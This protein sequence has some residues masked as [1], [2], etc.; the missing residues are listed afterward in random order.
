MTLSPYLVGL[1]TGLSLIIA[2]GA[3]NAFVLRH[4]LRGEHVLAVCLT[5]ALSDAIL[6][7]L[8]VTGFGRITALLPWL[9]EVM[10]YAGAA[11]LIWYGAR[12]LR[13]ALSS[14]AALVVEARRSS[15]GPGRTILA[16][17]AITWLNPHVWLDTVVL[18]GAI[19]TRF[20]DARFA[21]AAGAVSGSFLF[22]FALGYGAALVRPVFARPSSW[23]ALEFV[24]ALVMWGIAAGLLLG[25]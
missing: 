4:G 20:D 3:Q 17:L 18:L 13:S 8:G 19:S 14:D 2:I 10:R 6:I 9:A 5:C 23:R 7:V 1:M 15:D 25:A 21:F 11:F 12:S 22:F 24:I 16:C